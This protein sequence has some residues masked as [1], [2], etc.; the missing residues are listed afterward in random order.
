MRSQQGIRAL[1]AALAVFLLSAG[2]YL[3]LG[4]RDGS[5]ATVGSPPPPVATRLGF[6][7]PTGH[8]PYDIDA[9]I[10][11]TK[12]CIVPG[13]R[14]QVQVKLQMEIHNRSD[15]HSLDINQD[16]FRL[17]VRDFRIADWT[18]A[19]LGAATLAQPIHT[20]FRGE[21]VW[22]IPADAEES[23]DTIP[24]EPRN[25]TFATHWYGSTL[26]PGATFVPHYHYGDLVFYLPRT[27]QL[28][29]LQNVVG[30]AFMKNSDVL[31]LCEPD[32]WEKHAPAGTF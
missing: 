14:N 5:A 2:S 18:P 22:A 21:G 27:D 30:I 1:L 23:Y 8:N 29:P 10:H 28:K 12:W 3:G 4:A 6:V 15:K 32:V 11:V 19:R 24:H 16:N 26:A 25:L 17:I 9:W 7:C 20:T 31:A 13:V